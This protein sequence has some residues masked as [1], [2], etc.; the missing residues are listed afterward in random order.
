MYTV[1]YTD[2][3]ARELNLALCQTAF[4]G[5][6]GQRKCLNGLYRSTLTR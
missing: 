2:R 6:L 4:T 5:P 3:K 1:M